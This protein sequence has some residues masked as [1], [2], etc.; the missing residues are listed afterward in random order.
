[1]TRYGA[2]P[3]GGLGRAGEAPERLASSIC[4]IPP[5]KSGSD[6]NCAKGGTRPSGP[7][8]AKDLA[9]RDTASGFLVPIRIF[10]RKKDDDHDHDCYANKQ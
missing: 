10:A 1:M 7:V 9:Y 3:D 5:P 6:E 2:F 4:A 8:S